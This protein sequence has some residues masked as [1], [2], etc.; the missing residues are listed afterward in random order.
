M[1]LEHKKAFV[2][3]ILTLQ[4]DHHGC[5]EEA[6]NLAKEALGF[7]IDHNLIREMINVISEDEINKIVKTISVY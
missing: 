2:K 6:V 5:K 4:N 1:K 7:E 3:I